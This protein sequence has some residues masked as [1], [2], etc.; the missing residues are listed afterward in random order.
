MDVAYW[1][2]GFTLLN[3]VVI[4][5]VIMIGEYA[6]LEKRHENKSLLVSTLWKAVVFGVLAFAFHI[7]EE[8]VKRLFVALC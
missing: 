5:K 6:K 2:F 3:A 8:V 4:T 1:N 7:V